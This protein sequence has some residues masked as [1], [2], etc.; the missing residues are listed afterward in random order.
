MY[1]LR[2]EKDDFISLMRDESDR[3][4]RYAILSHTWG[5]AHQKAGHH[6]VL[7]LVGVYEQNVSAGR[8]VHERTLNASDNAA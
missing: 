3:V 2:I 4:L 6:E 1:I 8:L 5:S 7:R